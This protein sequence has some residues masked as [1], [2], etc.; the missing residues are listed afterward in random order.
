MLAAV[1]FAAFIGML[2]CASAVVRTRVYVGVGLGFAPWPYYYAPPVYYYPPP[3]YYPPPVVY[4]AP[5]PPIYYTPLP[6]PLTATPAQCRIFSG[7]ATNDQS[8][9]P[10]YGRACLWADGRWHIVN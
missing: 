5:P 1:A 9:Q 4:Y 7:D 3:I 10:F 8:G 2:D 6:P